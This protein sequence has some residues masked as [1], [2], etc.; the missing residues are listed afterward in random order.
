MHAWRQCRMKSDHPPGL[1]NYQRA[2]EPR[3]RAAGK[4]WGLGT[5]LSII[6]T[7]V[8][9]W[10]LPIDVY[11]IHHCGRSLSKQQ[12]AALLIFHGTQYSYHCLVL[13]TWMYLMTHKYPTDIARHIIHAN[14]LLQLLHMHGL[15]SFGTEILSWISGWSLRVP[16]L[17]TIHG[18]YSGTDTKI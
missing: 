6:Y 12:T 9:I 13:A 14:K 8:N 17:Y 15:L 18:S 4:M 11:T 16:F 2:R 1:I 7:S 10:L 5:R 3:A